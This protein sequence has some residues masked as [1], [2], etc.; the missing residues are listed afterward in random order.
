M[1][2]NSF[3]LT[4]L[5]MA[6]FLSFQ[7]CS[8]ETSNPTEEGLTRY[9]PNSGEAGHWHKEDATQQY[10]GE[11]LY[12]YIDGGADIYHEYGI[13]EVIVQDY[14]NPEGKEITLE[15][16]KM[17]DDEGA[18]GIYTFKRSTRGR[19]VELGNKGQI[20]DYYL[21]FWKNDVLVTLTGFEEE[22]QT[23]NG[24]LEIA[25][26]VD[27]KMEPGGKTPALVSL[28]PK[29]GVIKQSLKYLKGNIGLYNCYMFSPKN[30][31]KF[32]DAVKADFEEG[33][34]V[35]IFGYSSKAECYQRFNEATASI[36]EID[37]YRDFKT[38]DGA[39]LCHDE[40]DVVIFIRPFEEYVL[41]ALGPLGENTAKELID[42]IQDHIAI[43]HR[44]QGCLSL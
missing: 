14:R 37:K 35:Y 11:T 39:F 3:A 41:L 43:I 19:E 34:Q 22:Q 44:G 20:E 7:S 31:F 38:V 5:L 10:K 32:K 2:R 25:K 26:A 16:F 36:R 15:I 40:K 6:C 4:I 21:N 42:N 27:T 29:E 1:I 33:Y 23:I 28:I 24:L 30:I 12:D 18:Y 17:I 8:P 9:L 13:E